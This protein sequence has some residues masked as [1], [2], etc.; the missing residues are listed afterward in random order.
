MSN[1]STI[2]P[3]HVV[4]RIMVNY[5]DD[6]V[7]Y[8]GPDYPIG[9]VDVCL[10]PLPKRGS[11]AQETKKIFKFNEIHLNLLLS[12]GRLPWWWESVP[13]F[14]PIISCGKPTDD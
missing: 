1:R 13:Y 9:N 4:V 8:S 3:Q 5:A 7:L 2:I 14:K 6:S 12:N 11:Q 10:R